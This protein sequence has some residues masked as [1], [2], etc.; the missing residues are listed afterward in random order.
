MADSHEM[1][2]WYGDDLALRAVS[3]DVDKAGLPML[4]FLLD[5]L[6]HDG[7]W[8]RLTMLGRF[9]GAGLR[10]ASR[11]FV[12]HCQTTGDIAARLGLDP[13]RA[14]PGGAGGTRS[15]LRALGRAG[16]PRRVAW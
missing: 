16:H 4:R 3:Y 5:R 10:D 15:G 1:A 7:A 8:G 14:R 6:T 13:A 9:F 12:T 2:R 11:S